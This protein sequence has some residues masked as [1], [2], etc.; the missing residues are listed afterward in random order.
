MF[1]S[2]RVLRPR[3]AIIENVGAIVFRGLDRVL[4]DLVEIEYDAEWQGIRA[5]D[6]GAPHRRE[7][8]W[9][10]AYPHINSKST[11][12]FN[13]SKRQGELGK[14][15]AYSRQQPKGGEEKS[16]KSYNQLTRCCGAFNGQADKGNGKQDVA[17]TI[18]KHDDNA[19][20]GASE[21]CRERSEQVEVQGCIS[22][23]TKPGLEGQ[24]P[25]SKLSGRE[26]GLLAECNRSHPRQ[27]L[28][29]PCVGVLVDGL[30]AGLDRFEGRLSN[31]SYKKA[32]Q[33][34]G[35][36]NS[37]VPQIAELLF[38]RIKELLE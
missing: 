11:M 26:S 23:T 15:V 22:H 13:G 27:W 24:K 37:I 2:I 29:E 6:M 3:F 38:R 10:V 8:I 18:S 25:E 19:G 35:I 12:S 1:E 17:D 9:I 36:G 14:D 32:S 34:K 33:I 31:K 16:Q 7:R 21:V 28:P 4:A 20:Y 30:P 5:S